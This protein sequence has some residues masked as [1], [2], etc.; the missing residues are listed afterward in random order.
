ML[1][2]DYYAPTKVVFGKDAQMRCA[3]LVKE[4]GG[5]PVLA[6]PYQYDSMDIVPELMR[7]GLSGIEYCH[8]TQSGGRKIGVEETAMAFGLFLT[9]GSDAH[10]LYTEEV[11]PLGSME[12]RMAQKHPLLL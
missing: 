8:P 12:F 7:Y 4:C 5:S 11:Y 10:G 9:G 1:N 6:H 3:G 2:F